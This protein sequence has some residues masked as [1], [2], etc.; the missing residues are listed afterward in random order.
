MEEEREKEGRGGKQGH[1]VDSPSHPVASAFELGCNV[2]GS[3]S[4]FRAGKKDVDDLR[5]NHGYVTGS[6]TVSR[7]KM[8]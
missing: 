8:A 5:R 1:F 2:P 7:L 6:G 3:I 4:R